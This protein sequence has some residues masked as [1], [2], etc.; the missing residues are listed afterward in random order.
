MAER[1]V[2]VSA[3]SRFSRDGGTSVIYVLDGRRNLK[4]VKECPTAESV[5]KH[6]PYRYLNPLQTAFFYLYDEETD[7]SVLCVAPT[8]AGKTGLIYIFFSKFGGRK[9]YIAPTK[10]LCEEKYQEFCRIFG[11]SNVSLRTGDRFEFTPPQTEYVIATYES[12]LASIRSRSSWFSEVQA[13]C[14]DEIH[15]VMFG[16]SRGVFLEELIAHSISAGKSIL[17]LSA[18]VPLSAAEEYAKWLRATLFY[19]DWRPVPLERRVEPLAELERKLFG[20]KVKR[21]LHQRIAHVVKSLVS[22]Q[23]VIVFVHKKALGWKIVEEFDKLGLP[24][25]NETVPFDKRSVSPPEDSL[26]AFHNADIPLEER[27]EIEKHFR[28]GN[29]RFLVSTQ[30]MAYGVNLPADEAFIIVK[31]LTSKTLPDVS[32]ILQMEGRVGRFGFSQKGISRIVPISGDSALRR[33][34][35]SFSLSPDTRTSLEKLIEGE[36][37]ERKLSDIDAMSLLILGIIASN[38]IDLTDKKKGENKIKRVLSFMKTPLPNDVGSVLEILEDSGC[39]DDGRLT[40]LGKILSISFVPPSSYREFRKRFYS[41]PAAERM[42]SIAY[43]IRPLLFFRDF[44]RTFL[45]MLPEH[46]KKALEGKIA[47]LFESESILELW[48]NGDLWWY[49]KYPPSQ[50][51]LRPD[52]LQLVRFLSHLKFSELLDISLYDIMRI[53]L[54]LTYGVHP[55]FSIVAAVE[56]IGFSR[57]GSIAWAARELNQS[58]EHFIEDIKSGNKLALDTL[59]RT[60]LQRAEN[61]DPTLRSEWAYH[62]GTSKHQE[63]LNIISKINDEVRNIRELVSSFSTKTIDDEMARIMV[64]VRFGSK[65]ALEMSKEDLHVFVMQDGKVN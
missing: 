43:I 60:M 26:V 42:N 11:K 27:Q 31:T 28:H 25:L 17:S 54:S 40:P 15:F 3:D 57:T 14:V 13:I 36:E 33:E 41:I 4:I 58:L 9:L 59:H 30:T 34:L 1:R 48:M 21:E 61:I 18:T 63:R 55:D 49:F 53:G 2:I 19:S 7:G 45:D 37:N 52:A 10:A 32:T 62:H 16:G 46:L 39:I 38:D 24:V 12:C 8:S 44:S 51:Y 29:L 6:I 35:D 20:G 47:R 65:M 64:F 50:F 5:C 23:K 22:S 56:G